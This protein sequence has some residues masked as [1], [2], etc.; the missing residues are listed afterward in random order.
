MSESVRANLFFGFGRKRR[1]GGASSGL[2]ALELGELID[3]G[4]Y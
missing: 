2:G 3:S 1:L 4:I